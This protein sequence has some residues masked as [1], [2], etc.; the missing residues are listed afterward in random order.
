M[1][2]GLAA[3]GHGVGAP[4]LLL[5]T[6]PGEQREAGAAGQSLAQ[7]ACLG[8]DGGGSALLSRTGGE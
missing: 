7:L 2:L 8:T 4:T 6:A 5:A 3:Q 1:K